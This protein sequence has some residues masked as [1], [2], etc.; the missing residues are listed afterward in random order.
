MSMGGNNADVIVVGGGVVGLAV[1][2]RLQQRGRRVIVLERGRCGREAS[3]AGAGVISAANPHRSDAM[4]HMHCESIDAYES[5]CH[6]LTEL[7][8]VNT[9]YERC[10]SLD[11]LTT[12]QAVEMA[13]SDVRA[14][15]DQSMPDG[16]PVMEMIA[17]EDVR[18]FEPNIARNCLAFALRRKTA[19]VRNPRLLEALQTAGTNLGA[20]VREGIE[21]MRFVVE[22]D[23]VVGVDGGDPHGGTI[24]KFRADHV[25]LCAGAWSA[26]IGGGTIQDLF[27][28]YPVRGQ[29]ILLN[30]GGRPIRHVINRRD[31][32]MVCRGDGRLLAGATEEHESGFVKRNTPEGIYW[33]TL[34]AAAAVPKLTEMA[35][36]TMWAGLRPGTP[37]RRPYIGLVPGFPGLVAA[38][39][40]FRTGLTLAPVT[41]DIVCELIDTGSTNRD[42][43]RCAPGRS[44]GHSG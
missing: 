20:D 40:H 11:M 34:S 22:G 19:Q 37:D 43:R 21:V 15:A 33:L 24:Q 7:S 8:G 41:A 36:E 10:G 16:Q 29:I 28:V 26:G 4:Y 44:F 30:C 1:A 5:F 9:E 25:V 23:R 12:L 6:E 17:N 39:G 35:I 2:F 27:S 42:L 3:W 32:Y 14:T 13:Q 38:T 18:G 31:L